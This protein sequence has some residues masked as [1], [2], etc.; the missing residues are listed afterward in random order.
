M[1]FHDSSLNVAKIKKE[2]YDIYP[3]TKNSAML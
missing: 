3:N 2:L 1:Y